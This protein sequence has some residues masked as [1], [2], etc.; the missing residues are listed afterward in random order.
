[1]SALCPEDLAERPL[2]SVSFNQDYSCFACGFS[3]GFRIYNCDPFKETFRRVDFNGGIGICTMLF[4]CNLLALVG[5]GRNP[6]FPP[7]IVKIW[8]D[9]QNRAIGE[10]MFRSAVKAVLLRRDRVVVV[11]EQKVYVYRFSDLKLLDQIS[12]IS[13]RR[14]LCALCPDS[15]SVV[16]AC[17]GHKSGTVRVEL[18]DLRKSHIV[19]AHE[20]DLAAIALNQQGTRL[21]T[22]SEK[23]TLVRLFDTHT[24]ELLRELRRGTERA[25]INC[26]VFSKSTEHLACSSDKGTVHIFSLASL[27]KADRGSSRQADEEGGGSSGQQKK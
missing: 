5:G 18:Y 9:H 23:G 22:A 20:S 6:K 11:L 10:L 25:T 24:G 4:R 3:D 16:L 19:P 1:M 17:P 14:G 27:A 8:D 7:N 21:A 2:L 15:S 26:V 12:T 13:N